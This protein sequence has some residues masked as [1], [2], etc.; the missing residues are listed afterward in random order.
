MHLTLLTQ[1][2]QIQQQLQ[3]Q[4]QLQQQQNQEQEHKQI[5]Q[6]KLQHMILAVQLILLQLWGIRITLTT[7]QETLKI[8]AIVAIV[9]DQLIQAG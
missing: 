3:P 4:P 9:A 6:V 1:L 8:V 5:I 7:I 2:Y